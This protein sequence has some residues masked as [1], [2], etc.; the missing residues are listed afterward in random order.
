MSIYNGNLN[1]NLYK[2]KN[3]NDINIL[4]SNKY[5][6]NNSSTINTTKMNSSST[7]NQNY[8][9]SQNTFP[10]LSNCNTIEKEYMDNND[11]ININNELKKKNN[12]PTNIDEI[13]KNEMSSAVIDSFL[14]EHQIKTIPMFILYLSEIWK[15]LSREGNPQNDINFGINI[16]AF[17]KYYHLPG[18]I[19]QRLF[20]LMNVNRNGYLSP[21]EFIKGM[22]TLFGEEINSLIDFIFQFYDFDEDDYITFDDVHAVLCY[23]PIINGFDDMIDIEQE[24]HAT[25]DDI[26][27]NKKEKIDFNTFYDLIIR[28]ERYELFIPLISFFYDNKPF[29]NEEINEFYSEYYISGK[30]EL[31]GGNYKIKNVVNFK[32]FET[33]EEIQENKIFKMININN[34]LSYR[35]KSPS[36]SKIFK[37][38]NNEF[39]KLNKTAK[40]SNE[41]FGLF[42]NI[43][44]DKINHNDINVSNDDLD[45]E[46][47]NYEKYILN[48]NAFDRMRKSLPIVTGNSN[49]LNLK[50]ITKNKN[51]EKKEENKNYSK[52]IDNKINMISKRKYKHESIIL[53][54]CQN[55]IKNNC[56]TFNDEIDNYTEDNDSISLQKSVGIKLDYITKDEKEIPWKTNIINISKQKIKCES[57]LYKLTKS[58]KMKKLYFKLYNYDLFYFKN[59]NS[60]SHEGMHNLSTYFLELKSVFDNDKNNNGDNNN[61]LNFKYNQKYSQNKRTI[62]GIEYY[63]FLLINIKKEIHCYY[64][65]SL[66]IYK[67][68]INNLK[69]L[70]KYKNIYQ[71]YIFHQIV[72]KGKNCVVFSAYDIINKRDV[73]IKK[74]SKAALTL[75][76][77]SLIQTEVDTLKVCQH[78]YVVKL[79]E[80][81][82]TYNEVNIV[83]EYCELGNLYYYLSK[84]K[85][86]LSEE[87]IATYI[88]NISKAVYSMHNLGIIHR[89]LKL[90]NIALTKNNNKIEIRIL[91]FGLSKILGPNQLCN[92]GYGT[93]GYAAPEVINRYNYSFEADI[94][95]IGVICYFLCMRKLPFDYIRAGN[96]EMDMIENTLLDEVKFDYNI[97]KKYSKY[98]EKFIRDLM[99]KNTFERPT[100]T[101]ILEHP[102]FQLFFGK[103]VKNRIVNTYK[104]EFYTNPDIDD[105]YTCDDNI[106]NDNSKDIRANYLLYTNVNN[107]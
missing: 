7:I 19:G 18:L 104:K 42:K 101:E 70:L 75:E 97:M 36:N 38:N 76:D 21:N 103:E 102:W 20:N 96:N 35:Y 71:Q 29:N 90:S 98:A 107:K 17:N 79:Y 26:F 87:Q 82:E 65:P 9:E 95:S 59:E 6:Y 99:N 72:G 1:T 77:L 46:E 45:N 100:I 12:N 64:T 68:W 40:K 10:N 61:N 80:I 52:N 73:A 30:K 58:G 41:H 62:N 15:G 56:M 47:K 50:S 11:Q 84:N 60:K 8:Q 94:W 27:I 51:K 92:E 33:K 43:N 88:H 49:I 86:I 25:I 4:N 2:N 23:M 34:G 63:V 5:N 13:I 53:N 66:Q 105:L 89:D 69:I 14:K 78:P 28:K 54:F 24:I 93:P 106:E 57:Y 22:C 48:S 32:E 16:F 39:L 85:F 31:N 67:E 91:D 37:Y 44:A 74:I 81:I 55:V 83:L 3:K